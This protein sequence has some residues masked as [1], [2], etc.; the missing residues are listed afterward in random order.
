MFRVLHLLD[1]P[2][3]LADIRDRMD[4]I[5]LDEPHPPIAVNDHVRPL[6][7]AIFFTKKAIFLRYYPMRPEIAQERRFLN[8]K[9]LCPGPLTGPRIHTDSHGNAAHSGKSLVI[10]LEG[11]HLCCAELSPCKWVERKECGLTFLFKKPKCLV[12]LVLEREVLRRVSRP[13]H[14]WLFHDDTRQ[15]SLCL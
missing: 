5:N 9:A 13:D 15:E 4:R 6:G 8:C 3:H 12:V 7:K 11:R 14:W 1:E 10:I 2:D